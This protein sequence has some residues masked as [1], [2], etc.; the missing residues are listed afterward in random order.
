MTKKPAPGTV[1]ADDTKNLGTGWSVEGIR[2]YNDLYF[3][4]RSDRNQRGAFFN[5]ELL[6]HYNRHK[7][8]NNGMTP[9]GSTGKKKRK[10]VAF[11]DL[12]PPPEQYNE[13]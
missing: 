3:I 5:Q 7:E 8:L 11:D 1:K 12:N 9:K 2:R 4:V 13:L 6:L 10:I